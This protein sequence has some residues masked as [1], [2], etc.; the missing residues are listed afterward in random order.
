MAAAGVTI[1]Q[2]P[3]FRTQ[4]RDL[5]WA[6]WFAYFAG[7]GF[8]L[9]VYPTWALLQGSD[10]RLGNY[11]S[12]FYSPELYGSAHA[13]ISA[14]RPSWWPLMIPFSAALLIMWAPAGFRLT[15]YYYRGAYYK[16]FFLDPPNCTVGEARH[17]Y[18]GENF[19]PLLIQNAHRYFMYIAVV[20]LFFLARDVWEA[21]WFTNPATG[22][23]VFG[24]GVGSVI[25]AI[26]VILIAGYTLGCHSL[27]SLIGGNR[28]RFS[29]AALRAKCWAC[30]TVFNGRHMNWAWASLIWVS[31]TDLY[32]RLC[33]MGVVHDFRVLF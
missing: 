13:W 33:A 23:I 4:R 2:T 16:A 29:D 19:W 26:N 25:L 12:P 31:F 18:W 24:I 20:F 11:L 5:W 21:L 7:L 32:I 1:T 17:G 14:G 3:F 15:C 30:V 8:L 22:R 27:R 10:Y 28:D 9:I 6:Q